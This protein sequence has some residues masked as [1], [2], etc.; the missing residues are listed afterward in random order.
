LEA[1]EKLKLDMEPFRFIVSRFS[2][3]GDFL[4][5]T[6][7]EVSLEDYSIVED[8]EQGQDITISIQLKQYKHYA[9]Q[10]LQ[11]IPTSIDTNTVKT[12]AVTTRAAKKP[13]KTYTV[14]AG[15]TLWKIAKKE[16]GDGSKYSTIAS[17]NGIRNPNLIYPGQV[18]KLG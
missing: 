12:K 1:I 2:P 18:I 7:M 9:T 8:A 3:A 15:D 13:A 11:V 10:I 14:K 17:L 6:N 4:F 5:D 16:L